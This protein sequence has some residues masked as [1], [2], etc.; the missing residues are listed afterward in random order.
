M[1]IVYLL[2]HSV[3]HQL[4]I[5]CTNNIKRRLIQHNSRSNTSTIR[6]NGMWILIYMEIY[7]NKD[8]AFEREGKLKAHGSGKQAL[9]RRITRSRLNQK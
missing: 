4:Y 8:D 5:A 9:Y 1:H 6:K 7:R 2:E 3:T